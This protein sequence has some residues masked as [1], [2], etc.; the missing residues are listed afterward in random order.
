M[1]RYNA[2]SDNSYLRAVGTFHNR[3][4]GAT[5][6]PRTNA[7]ENGVRRKTQ[8]CS[9]R[10][11]TGFGFLAG[12]VGTGGRDGAKGFHKRPGFGM[13]KASHGHPIAAKARVLRFQSVQDKRECAPWKLP[14]NRSNLVGNLHEL[15]RLIQR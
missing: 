2:L 13:S 4:N 8:D 3:Q 15:R 7:T 6:A 5:F 10:L 1:R 11:S 9:S 14:F 12:F